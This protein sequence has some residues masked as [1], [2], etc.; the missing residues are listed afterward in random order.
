MHI[1]LKKKDFYGINRVVHIEIKIFPLVALFC[2]KN[3]K[4]NV[5]IHGFIKT[6][7]ILYKH[8]TAYRIYVSKIIILKIRHTFFV[9]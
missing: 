7:L 1:L 2:E 3:V 4:I 6:F 9:V 5:L 8:V